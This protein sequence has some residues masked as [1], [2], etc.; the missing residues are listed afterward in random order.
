MP[1]Y[2]VQHTQIIVQLSISAQNQFDK[3]LRIHAVQ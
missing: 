1:L 2:E 3:H